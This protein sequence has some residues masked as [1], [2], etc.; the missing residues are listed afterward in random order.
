MYQCPKS[1]NFMST[2]QTIPVFNLSSISKGENGKTQSSE[3]SH[4]VTLKN[5]IFRLLNRVLRMKVEKHYVKGTFTEMKGNFLM[6]TAIK[7]CNGNL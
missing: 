4:T 5:L 3:A 1:K 7:H 6:S 2:H